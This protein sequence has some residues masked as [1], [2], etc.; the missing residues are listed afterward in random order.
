MIK[1]DPTSIVTGHEQLTAIFGRWPSFHDAEVLSV[2]LERD[3]RDR[4]ESPA[5]YAKVHVFAGRRN[6]ASSTGV[7]F[8]NHTLV[9]FRFNQVF[10][11]EHRST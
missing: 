5:L 3:G 9:T 1:Q 4:W 7:E 8:Y 10:D 11:L 6:E 2:R